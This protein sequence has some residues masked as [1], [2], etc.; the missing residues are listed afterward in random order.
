MICLL[1]KKNF[2]F[3]GLDFSEEI[4]YLYTASFLNRSKLL[5]YDHAITKFF[6]SFQYSENSFIYV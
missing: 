5:I 3:E 6:K 1:S 2:N 4:N